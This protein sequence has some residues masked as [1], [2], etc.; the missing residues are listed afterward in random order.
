M[1][2]KV[3]FFGV[4]ADVTGQQQVIITHEGKL[5]TVMEKLTLQYPRLSDYKFI[6]CI[7]SR[8]SEGN[9]AIEPGITINLLPPFSGG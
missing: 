5:K 7:E 2:V 9:E 1:S 3:N 6:T 8:V 4:L